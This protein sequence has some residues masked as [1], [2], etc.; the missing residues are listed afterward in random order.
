VLHGSRYIKRIDAARSLALAM[1]HN[2]AQP[3]TP[4]Q[5]G[6]VLESYERP[7][8]EIPARLLNEM[9]PMNEAPAA[10][11]P[12][13]RPWLITD[14]RLVGRLAD[15]KLYGWRWQHLT[16]CRV[17]LQFGLEVV[18]LDTWDGIP[19]AWAG[20]A[21]APLAV[22]AIYKLYGPT[23]LLDHPGLAPL[24]SSPNSN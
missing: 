9:P 23:A 20:P 2:R 11:S 13:V 4:Y 3:V 6:V 7:L 8:I 21:V 12:P 19:L 10:W 18:T 17:G 24:R 14:N 1:Y 22:A 16:G 15:D 5:V